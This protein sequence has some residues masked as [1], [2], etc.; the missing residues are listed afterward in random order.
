M[1]KQ[2]S[3]LPECIPT[4]HEPAEAQPLA[5]RLSANLE[6]SLQILDA[7]REMKASLYHG[8]HRFSGSARP[9]G[10]GTRGRGPEQEHAPGAEP[11][12]LLKALSDRP[13]D[14][15]DREALLA[16]GH[17]IDRDYLESAAQRMGLPPE[18]I[19]PA[20]LP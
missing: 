15:L 11:L 19:Q 9:S 12:I 6:R 5:L 3:P 14:R 10:Q 13:Q 4:P 8:G 7:L 1:K 2:A 18:S 17:P 20:R 16:C